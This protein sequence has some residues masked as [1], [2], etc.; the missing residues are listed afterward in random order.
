MPTRKIK[1]GLICPYSMARGGGVQEIVRAMRAEL[2]RR[3]HECLIITPQPREIEGVDTDGILFVGASADFRSPLGTTSQV[4]T[5]IDNEAL[6]QMLETE[7]FD[8]LHFH[9]P[10]VPFLSRQILIRSKSINVATFH[11][12]VPETILSRTVVRSVM[13][14]TVGVLKYLDEI[15]A[16]SPAAAEF[17]GSLTKQPITIIP[18]AINVK[19]FM[20]AKKSV[21][22]KSKAKK[23]LYVGRLEKRKGLKYLFRAWQLVAETNPMA[24]LIIAGDGSDRR[25]LEQLAEELEL[26]RISFVGYVTDQ[27]K[28]KLMHEADLFCS[29]AIYGESFG[30]VLLE[31]MAAGT[32]LVAGNNSGYEY[33]L[34]GLGAMSLVSPRDSKEFARRL[35]LFLNQPELTKLWLK[36]ASQYVKQ[37]DYKNII[38]QYEGFYQAALAR[39]RK[40]AKKV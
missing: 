15:T 23:V 27:E 12:K 33:V 16:V 7:K 1:I 25:K 22:P 31:A 14:Y 35:D 13:P 32:P 28:I 6:E 21:K 40:K 36:W 3:G 5:S 39:H 30:I 34:D 8:I 9:E 24:E 37:F 18:N 29:P 11:A 20:P 38:D 19:Y 10:W 17:I 2:V 26:P 4:S